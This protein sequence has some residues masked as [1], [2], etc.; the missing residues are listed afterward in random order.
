MPLI[1]SSSNKA[2]QKNIE[3][4]I[5]AGK[6][7]KQAAAIAYN[8]QRENDSIESDFEFINSMPD[9]KI[10]LKKY[11]IELI[12]KDERNYI[13]KKGPKEYT[14]YV[15][16]N[17]NMVRE[18]LVRAVY[19]LSDSINDSKIDELKQEL[20]EVKQK[21][22]TEPF[23]LNPEND[24]KARKLLSRKREL[25]KL[26]KEGIKDDLYGLVKEPEN[27]YY[28][29]TFEEHSEKWGDEEH[30]IYVKAKN[31]NEAKEKALKVKKP[32]EKII[33]IKLGNHSEFIQ[34]KRRGLALDSKVKDFPKGVFNRYFAVSNNA[35]EYY[36]SK[37][38]LMND[39]K[40]FGDEEVSV[41]SLKNEKDIQNL[42]SEDLM[43][44]WKD[45]K[46]IKKG[47]KFQ[48]T[49][50]NKNNLGEFSKIKYKGKRAKIA[51]I[52][53]KNRINEEPD[54]L[55]VDPETKRLIWAE[56]KDIEVVDSDIKDET[57]KA[58]I[59]N[60]DGKLLETK[61]FSSRIQL[62]NYVNNLGNLIDMTSNKEI[63]KNNRGDLATSNVWKIVVEDSNI[64]DYYQKVN[65]KNSA[66]GYIK[67]WNGTE[68]LYL[69]FG[70]GNSLGLANSENEYIAIVKINNNESMKK[71]KS[72][73]NAKNYLTGNILTVEE[74]CRRLGIKDSKK[75][76]L[77]HKDKKYLVKAVDTK[78][79]VNKLRKKLEDK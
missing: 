22:E 79:A 58:V 23:T 21:L 14:F 34:A 73:D 64:K 61:Q 8:I 66:I 27:Y 7:P 78:E 48:D 77:T 60:K 40:N 68:P 24:P 37:D 17:P 5:K 50:F 54:I 71:F 31:E 36:S 4:E 9:A 55:I 28:L 70:K 12:K 19:R 6:D 46:I 10:V 32:N 45:G 18:D 57:I 35:S 74:I 65:N 2:L 3:T 53:W 56:P 39:L 26:I 13:L 76:L 67:S 25:E 49:K 38:K 59:Y 1:Q 51:R 72:I 63:Y 43:F 75:F 52:D 42:T 47:M 11:G 33:R 29:V 69:D 44:V 20:F 30:S 41:Y 62:D 16:S 15:L